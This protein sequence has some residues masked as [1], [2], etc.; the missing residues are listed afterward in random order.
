MNEKLDE[1]NSYLVHELDEQYN[2]K[3][4]PTFESAYNWLSVDEFVD[5]S[6]ENK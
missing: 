2:I 1:I 3:Y 4:Q 6:E 5:L